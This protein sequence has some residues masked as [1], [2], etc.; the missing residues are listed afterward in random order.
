MSNEELK[1]EVGESARF[2]FGRNWA[3]Y[4]ALVDNER[5]AA[6]EQS[7]R[8]MLERMTTVDGRYGCNEYVF[9]APPADR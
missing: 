3:C 1:A 4:L 2:G 5:I 8:D 9:R 6:A 7:L